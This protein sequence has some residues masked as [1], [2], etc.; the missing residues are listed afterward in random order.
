MVSK[1]RSKDSFFS[2]STIRI[3]FEESVIHP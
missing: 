1:H 3:K 2:V